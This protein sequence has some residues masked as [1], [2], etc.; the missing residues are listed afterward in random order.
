MDLLLLKSGRGERVHEGYE[1]LRADL[2]EPVPLGR[3]AEWAGARLLGPRGAREELVRGLAIDS[4]AVKEGDLFVALPGEYA[5]GH[6]FLPDV[7]P[8]ALAALVSRPEE[9][10]A[11]TRLEVESV[12]KA[13]LRMGGEFRRRYPELVVVG[14][15]GSV[16]KTTTK[17]YLGAI[18][19]RFA[20]TV[21]SPGNLNTVYGVPLTLA[22]LSRS[23]RLAVVEMG[24]QWSGEIA[25]L[26]EAA[27]P[28]MG[29]ITA[30]GSAHLEFFK[31]VRGIALAK[32]EL[33]A[34]LPG[35]G[36]A[37]LPLECEHFTTL[38]EHAPCPVVTFGLHEGD[39]HAE[40]I[41]QHDG[42]STFVT[43]WNPPA[44]VPSEAARF[45]VGLTN[46]GKHHVLS[47]VRAA[48][49]ALI[50]SVPPETVAKALADAQTTPLR[51][52][53]Y[54]RGGVTIL[55]DSYNANPLSMSAALETLTSLAGRPVAVLGDMLEL[56]PTAPQLHYSVGAEAAERGVA[57]LIAVGEYAGEI[58]RGARDS[59]LEELYE[60]ADRHGA[61]EILRRV[62]RRGD[63]LLVKAS[64]ALRLD[65][66][67]SEIEKF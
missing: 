67:L 32:A 24:M 18:L 10:P 41:V 36:A 65:I 23:V 1:Q 50:L 39:C 2:G 25:S 3:L 63:V 7:A 12:P 29:I 14:V 54:R 8:K 20:P 48:A 45:E 22:Q 38:T 59:G 5:D 40:G 43:V 19:T 35:D 27:R 21:V 16:G 6:D 9:D 56:G 33:L 61:L 13:L 44:E 46:P 62:L 60:A 34:G 15:T 52:E 66:L 64:R 51:G 55:A 37:V 28:K 42:G 30:V 49:A 58:A 57:V 31:D 47:A 11:L 26:V 17:D 4:R 53:V